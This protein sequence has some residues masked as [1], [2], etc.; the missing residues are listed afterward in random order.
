MKLISNVW[1]EVPKLM[2][3]VEV[4]FNEDSSVFDDMLQ[5]HFT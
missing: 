1:P 3:E 4:D 2:G 5:S